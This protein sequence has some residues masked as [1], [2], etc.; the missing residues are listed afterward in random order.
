MC[1]INAVVL[2][3]NR[4]ASVEILGVLEQATALGYKTN[5]HG[6][7]AFFNG[8]G[9][10]VK[11]DRK[12][13][14]VTHAEDVAK[15]NVII[16]HQRWATSGHTSKY[17]HPFENDDFILVHNGVMH[18][19]VKEGH[20]DTHNMFETFTDLFSKTDANLKRVDR[21]VLAIQETFAKKSGTYSVL[22]Y[23]KKTGVTYYTKESST[24]I[25]FV[26]AYDALIISTEDLEKYLP[27]NTVEI[28]IKPQKVYAMFPTSEDVFEMGEVEEYKYVAPVT[29]TVHRPHNHSNR[30]QYRKQR[31]SAQTTPK[32]AGIGKRT[33]CK[34]K[35]N[36]TVCKIRVKYLFTSDHDDERLCKFCDEAL[37]GLPENQVECGYCH[38]Q[39]PKEKMQY[40][41][42]IDAHICDECIYEQAQEDK[43]RQGIKTMMGYDPSDYYQS[44]RGWYD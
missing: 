36:C 41:P 5:N 32:Y 35:D 17:H 30:F 20:S 6:E 10:L 2:P 26:R 9:K 44:G 16:T 24:R 34:G 27:E 18:T 13:L 12:I 1:T 40:E 7:G 23:D 22:I 8:T 11:G 28:D 39:G 38:W 4:K 15:S 43:Q 42:L 21:T 33:K 37:R 19:F 31:G 3:K 14:F 29:T 25:N